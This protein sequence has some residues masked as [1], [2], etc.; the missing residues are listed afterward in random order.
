MTQVIAREKIGI[1]VITCNRPFLFRECITAI[2]EADVIVVVNDGDPYAT[3]AYPSRVARVIQ[4]PRNQGVAKSKNDALRFLQVAGCCHVFLCEDDMRVVHPELCTE[5]I[6]ASKESGILHFN[7]GY[8]GPLNKS[9]SGVAEPRK[10]VDYG[11]GILIGLNRHLVGAFTYYREDVLR[12]CG[13][14]HPLYPNVLEH[15]DHTFQIIRKGYHP[16]FWW[17]ADLANS[18]R[19][20]DDLDPDLTK[21]TI[22]RN[23]STYRH[24]WRLSNLYF[25]LRNGRRV[26]QIPDVEEQEV[27][28]V[29]RELKQRHSRSRPDSDHSRA[30]QIVYQ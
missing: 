25:M 29:L 8:H 26:M 5:Y 3:T 12:K 15:V 10:V 16:P 7:F 9:A 17:F 23:S 4:H 22:R 2:P 20:I 6:R 30:D 19:F 11:N 21:S 14:M 27:D 18:W 13:L 1:G 28:R 24:L